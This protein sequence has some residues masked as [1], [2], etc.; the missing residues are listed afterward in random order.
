MSLSI[1]VTALDIHRI[2]TGLFAGLGVSLNLAVIPAVSESNDQLPA[3]KLLYN[4]GKKIAIGTML[5][6]TVSGIQFYR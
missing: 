3:F 5:I 4:N 1:P 6:A 2:S